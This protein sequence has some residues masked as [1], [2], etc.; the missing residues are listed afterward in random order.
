VGFIQF[1]KHQTNDYIWLQLCNNP[2]A[3]SPYSRALDL[4]YFDVLEKEITDFSRQGQII[5]GGDLNARTG[6]LP[7]FI[8]EDKDDHLPLFDDLP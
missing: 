2:P 7:D 1:L 4:D 5:L 3:D 6:S 8:T